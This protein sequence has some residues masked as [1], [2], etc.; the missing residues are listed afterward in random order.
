MKQL[1]I[2]CVVISMLCGSTARADS[3]YPGEPRPSR[4]WPNDPAFFLKQ[5]SPPIG[6]RPRPSIP[7]TTPSPYVPG[8][9]IFTPPDD[10]PWIPMRLQPNHPSPGRPIHE[11]AS[12]PWPYGIRV[13][14][15]YKPAPKETVPNDQPSKITKELPAPPFPVE[16]LEPTPTIPY[17]VIRPANPWT[18][19][20]PVIPS[21]PDEP[22][23]H[24]AEEESTGIK[25]QGRPDLP[26]SDVQLAS[27]SHETI[28]DS[29]EMEPWAFPPEE[30][31]ASGHRSLIAGVAIGL[32]CMFLGLWWIRHPQPIQRQPS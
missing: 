1:M 4:P 2:Y 7:E 31:A 8:P 5:P 22:V 27:W 32:G 19:I 20:E 28:G 24:A 29:A 30:E 18:A 3:A 21:E 16:I 11:A 14:P 6:H 26:D 9:H 10:T 25:G 12:E 13:N 17:R 23:T 15:Q